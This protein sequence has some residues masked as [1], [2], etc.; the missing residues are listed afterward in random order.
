[1]V[2]YLIDSFALV[3]PFFPDFAGV[4]DMMGV[5]ESL[6]F[7]HNL[8]R[9]GVHGLV[10]ETLF[11]QANAVLAGKDAAQI[12]G[13]LDNLIDAF[14]SARVMLFIPTVRKHRR[15]EIAVAHVPG[16]ADGNVIAFGAL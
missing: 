5:E 7:F 11:F 14:Q 8:Y 2:F 6:Y 4:E 9:G 10:Q 16:E 13:N 1:M 15:V 3:L 12:E